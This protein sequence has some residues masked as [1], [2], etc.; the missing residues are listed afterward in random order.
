[1]KGKAKR[2]E[3]K[4]VAPGPSQ[5]IAPAEAADVRMDQEVEESEEVVHTRNELLQAKHSACKAEM[6]ANPAYQALPEWGK[7]KMLAELMAMH[8]QAL[9]APS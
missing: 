5:P 9:D 6:M 4:G 7:S 2:A 3:P 1:M 8:Q